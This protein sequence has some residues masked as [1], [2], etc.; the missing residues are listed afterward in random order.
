M[1]SSSL[2]RATLA[3]ALFSLP[4]LAQQAPTTSSSPATTTCEHSDRGHG[5]HRGGHGLAKL[6]HRLDRRV[7]EGRLSQ[8]QAEQFKTEAR[9]LR[10]EMK[11]A[12]ESKGAPLTE[13]QREQFRERRHSLQE[14]IRA[15][16]APRPQG[17]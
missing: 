6:E 7:S 9:Q 16:V 1:R 8:A 4:A 14:R 12:R 17:A 3:V 15:A 13:A 2:L 11:A 10:D 5:G